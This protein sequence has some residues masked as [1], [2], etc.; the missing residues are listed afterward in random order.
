MNRSP[1]R[2]LAQAPLALEPLLRPAELTG[3]LRGAGLDVASARACYLR[4]KPETGAL[5]GLELVLRDADGAER[6]WPGYL[7]VHP[8]ARLEELLGKWHAERVTATPFGP[9]V[10]PVPG[11]GAALFL[12]PDDAVVRGLRF[13]ADKAK[14]KRLLAA[15]PG[16][17]R[18]GERI[19]GKR[20]TSSTVR[21]KPERRLIQRARLAIVDDASGTER[22]VRVFLRSFADGRGFAIER[23]ARGL[24]AAGLAAQVPESLGCLMDGRLHVETE[25]D[26]RPL[27]DEVTVGSADPGEL[28]QL[29]GAFHRAAPQGQ[30]RLDLDAV[31]ARA[32]DNAAAIEALAPR[33]GPDAA[34]VHELLRAAGSA[35]FDDTANAT[36]HGDAH[37]HQFL[38]TASGLAV[39]DFER[40]ARG[41]PLFDL[42]HLR[43]HLALLARRSPDAA[44][45]IERF[46]QDL[47]DRVLRSQQGGAAR[48]LP[49]FVANG[50]L[51]RALLPLRN[52]EPDREVT[53]AD[54]LAMARRWLARSPTPVAVAAPRFFWRDDLEAFHPRAEG[55]W[56]GRVL[57]S[58]GELRFGEYLPSDDVF[59]PCDP[60]DDP[61]LPALRTALSSGEL[62]AYRPARRATLRIGGGARFAKVLRP[63]RAEELARRHESIAD[64]RLRLGAPF[65]AVATLET[66]IPARGLLVFA[67][68]RG[69]SL[70]E[71][72]SDAA[73]DPDSARRALHATARGL[74]ALH[75]APLGASFPA[76]AVPR[77][78]ADWC[79]LV[80]AHDAALAIDCTALAAKLRASPRAPR[81][82]LVHADAHDRNLFVD[83]AG[84]DGDDLTLIDLDASGFGDPAE[85]VGNLA[86]HVVFR[87]IAA[88]LAWD[89]G[90]DDAREFLAAYRRHAHDASADALVAATASTF[91][92]LACVHRFRRAW[93]RHCP[94]LLECA[95]QTAARLRSEDP[96]R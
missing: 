73:G 45:A 3:L 8:A 9:G 88:G 63:R 29:L 89:H 17:L 87:A 18:A 32:A 78:L 6:A 30:P 55:N 92:R 46:A 83:L 31:L 48:R 10:R 28:A 40:A 38:R 91:L 74:A 65:P 13:V 95:T 41:D 16:L 34:H 21:Y 79:A 20:S 54:T 51:E 11:A 7:R 66:A 67:A 2:S 61:A 84:P 77:S 47:V 36:L 49:F 68:A 70:R 82:A 43:A 85:D 33:L 60:V 94:A 90:W 86:A 71:W 25:L 23:L 64:L 57:A 69:R 27:L 76:A 19:S 22:E 52:L 26:A 59:R 56:P 42:G 39:V 4:L 15:M 75:R 14:L 12:F 35:A 62:V 96:L 1:L 53:A 44:P 24:R 80:R 5:V 50:L 93:Q 37:L 72:L 81:R 58:N